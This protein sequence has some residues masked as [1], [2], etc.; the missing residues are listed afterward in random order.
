MTDVRPHVPTEWEKMKT[1]QWYEWETKLREW[2]LNPEAF[3]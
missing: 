2:F 1:K 3:H